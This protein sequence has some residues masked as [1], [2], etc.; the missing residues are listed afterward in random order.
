MSRSVIAFSLYMIES[1]L[2]SL[3]RCLCLLGIIQ[4]D[5]CVYQHATPPRTFYFSFAHSPEKGK[6]GKKTIDKK[7]KQKR[8]TKSLSRIPWVYTSRREENIIRGYRLHAMWCE[9]R[10][11]LGDTNNNNNTSHFIIKKEKKAIYV[12]VVCHFHEIFASCELIF[13]LSQSLV[14]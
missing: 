12:V 6:T 4:I 8:R 14:R 9:C 3:A 13:P 1:R 7:R 11:N 10:K 2:D 5:L